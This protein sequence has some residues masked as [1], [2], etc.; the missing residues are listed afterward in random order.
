MYGH[1]DRPGAICGGHLRR[2]PG[3]WQLIELAMQTACWTVIG[4]AIAFPF[5]EWFY[6]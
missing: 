3:R 6:R 2:R 4:L 1:P 5:V